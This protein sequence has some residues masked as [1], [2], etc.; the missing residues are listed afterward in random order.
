MPT[1]PPPPT[2]VRSAF[3]M[4]APAIA[5]V[6]GAGRFTR[7]LQWWMP[8]LVGFP[9][10]GSLIPPRKEEVDFLCFALRGQGSR[11]GQNNRPR[12]SRWAPKQNSPGR[13]RGCIASNRSLALAVLAAA[14][15]GLLLA[16]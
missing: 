7:A 10:A 12:N 13:N 4:R 15:S 16:A 3:S 1:W 8:R 9:P 14:L 6:L 11:M 5:A 2:I